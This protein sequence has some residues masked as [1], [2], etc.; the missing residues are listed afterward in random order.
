MHSRIFPTRAAFVLTTTAISVAAFSSFQVL[1]RG[2]TAQNAAPKN[3]EELK[4]LVGYKAVDDYVKSDMIVG[5]GTGST[6]YYAVERVGQKLK[7]GELKNIKCIPT[8]EKTKQQAES[9]KIPLITLNDV[10]QAIDVSIDGADDVDHHLCL[11]KGGGGALL[12]EK[13]VE[14]VSKKF[15]CIVDESKISKQLG[16]KFPLPVEIVPF[17]YEHTMRVIESLPSLKG[18]KAILRYGSVGNNKK[19]GDKIA[20]TDNGNYIVDLHFSDS[21]KDI[22]LAARELT[23][24][25]GVVEHGLFVD[26]ASVVIV[27]G[28]DGKIRELHKVLESVG[29]DS[30]E[31]AAK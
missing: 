1:N 5:L 13:M 30:A 8:S 28:N 27:A 21:I 2:F 18:C 19:D 14:I 23:H 11:I 9:L 22:R 26:M 12:R 16:P 24:V 7:S 29:L 17:A 6:A 4:K 25:V 20:I 10:H 3:Q 15:V 31:V